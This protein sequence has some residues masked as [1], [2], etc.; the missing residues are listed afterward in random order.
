MQRSYKQKALT[1]HPDKGGTEE[2]FQQ[3]QTM[4]ERI[5]VPTDDDPPGS[6]G[7]FGMHPGSPVALNA[8]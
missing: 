7:L 8:A 5:H 3:L 6:G 4:L 2:D 1:A